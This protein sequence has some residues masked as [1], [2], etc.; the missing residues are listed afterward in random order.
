V[1]HIKDKEADM[2]TVRIALVTGGM[3]GLGETICV[4][5]AAL[6]YTVVTTHSPPT[7]RR[8]NGVIQ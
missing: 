5:V 7:P 2:E 3:D 1:R 4:K 8:R 6:G